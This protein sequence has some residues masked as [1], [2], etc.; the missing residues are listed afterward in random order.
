MYNYF[1]IVKMVMKEYTLPAVLKIISGILRQAIY[2]VIVMLINSLPLFDI[3]LPTI[4]N[5]NLVGDLHKHFLIN[6]W[7]DIE[8]PFLSGFC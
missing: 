3:S 6:S 8:Q 5:C 4:L 7:W 2:I 1:F